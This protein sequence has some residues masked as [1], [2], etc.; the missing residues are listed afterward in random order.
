ML[1]SRIG[2]YLANGQE[3]FEMVL[4]HGRNSTLLML[5]E[6][7]QGLGGGANSAVGQLFLDI[8]LYILGSDSSV[9]DMV[10]SF[11][12]RLFPL[13]YR[14]LLAGGEGSGGAVSEECLRGAWGATGAFGPYPKLAMTRLSR[15]LLATRVFLQALNLGIEVV[16]TTDH[17]RLGRDCGRALLRLW[18]CPRCQGLPEAPPCRGACL[19]AVQGCLG[20]AGEVQPH[21]RGYVEGLGA[22]D[23]AMRG[24]RGDME[25]AVLRLP[26]LVRLALRHALSARGRLVSMLC[27]L[28]AV[29]PPAP[30][31][32]SQQHVPFDP[33]ETLAGRRRE[34]INSLR[35]FN[36]F[37]SGLGEALCSR[38]A[39]VLND[40]PLLERTGREK[41]AEPL[42]Q[43]GRSEPCCLSPF[44]VTRTVPLCSDKAAVRSSQVTHACAV[45]RH[46][47][48]AAA[49]IPPV[50]RSGRGVGSPAPGSKRAQAHST[51][52]KHRGPEPVI[53]QIIDKLKHINQLLP[54]VTVPER[55]WRARPRGGT[56]ERRRDGDDDDEEGE[57]LV[58]G[59]CDDEDECGELSGLGP[60]PR[61]KRLRIFADLE[62]LRTPA[63][64]WAACA[65]YLMDDISGFSKPGENR[66][67]PEHDPLIVH[68]LR[69]RQG[70]D[71]NPCQTFPEYSVPW[72]LF[73]DMG[74]CVLSVPQGEAAQTD[75]AEPGPVLLSGPGIH[76]PALV[77]A[78]RSPPPG[79][80]L[81]SGRPDR[82]R[83][84]HSSPSLR[85]MRTLPKNSNSNE[86]HQPSV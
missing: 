27:S 80:P 75:T 11:F 8:S 70:G 34:F 35:S 50:P 14:R 22:L 74:L 44:G 37:Y 47:C 57:G 68:P 36:T 76:H 15:P 55:P 25:V 20:G 69:H 81:Q 60:P 38:E 71:I 73:Q 66:R 85:A 59:D 53:S 39:V 56:M 65:S 33:E 31:P 4:R 79:S 19:A 63:N 72:E 83:S 23:A 30:K 26:A 84:S 61:R 42:N 86:L 28:L 41:H 32:H 13:A 43:A 21:W 24:E 49:E 10:T 51:E 78:A 77:L 29:P 7:F 40:S 16:N 5:R 17:L 6:E 9:D 52:S 3:A 82:G 62:C 67:L 12:S 58:S 48:P 54:L 45:S 64:G 2:I 46:F 1:L 18:Y